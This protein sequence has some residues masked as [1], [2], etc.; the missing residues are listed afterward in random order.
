MS[1]EL[2]E[3]VTMDTS[4]KIWVKSIKHNQLYDFENINFT[5]ENLI[6]TKQNLHKYVT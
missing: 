3:T 1:K 4:S 6:L 5:C 2:D